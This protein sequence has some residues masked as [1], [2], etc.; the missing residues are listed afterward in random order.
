[1]QKAL[2]TFRGSRAG[3]DQPPDAHAGDRR[4]L[5][6]IN[7]ASAYGVWIEPAI[8]MPG[9]WYWRAGRVHHLTP[10]ENRGRHHIYVDVLQPEP[11]SRGEA[12]RRPDRTPARRVLGA[13][14]AIDWGDDAG[15]VVIDRHTGRQG[16]EY[17]LWRGQV[18]SVRALGVAGAE[19]PSD[20]VGGV[21]PTHPEEGPGNECDRHSF[22][23]IFYKAQA[24]AADA[25]HDGSL[26][27]YVLFGPP[28]HPATLANL[29]LA[30]DYLLAF[31]PTFGF[32]ADE[33]ARAREVTL[34]GDPTAIPTEVET[35]LAAAGA[36]V[37][38]VQ[39]TPG[40]LTE[41]LARRIEGGR[42]F[43]E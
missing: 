35:R 41:L 28:D 13:R 6:A 8:V 38:R 34:I 42:P 23:I 12:A 15:L 30:Q 9:D 17:P 36:R 24:P 29:W 2:A 10:A 32:K 43:V 31:R 39:G 33:A 14:V 7:D 25:G 26:A 16:A 20:C 11:S 4:P 3:P 18:C 22:A 5:E 19:L 1:M 27:H 40:E 37:Q 21:C